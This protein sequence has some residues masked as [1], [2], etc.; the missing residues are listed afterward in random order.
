MASGISA[1]EEELIGRERHRWSENRKVYTRKIHKLNKNKNNNNTSNS[2]APTTTHANNTTTNNTDTP[3]NSKNNNHHPPNLST[4]APSVSA[5][6][7]A[8]NQTNENNSSK[9]NSGSSN[10]GNKTNDHIANGT[11]AQESEN[12]NENE[13][14]VAQQKSSSSPAAVPVEE[15]NSSQPQLIST[16]LE[17]CSED[18][19][20]L[21]R[22]EPPVPNG[23]DANLVNRLG[24]PLVT[25]V[26]NRVNISVSAASSK[27]GVRELKRQLVDELSQVRK[28]AK[29]LEDKEIH[30][31]G[32]SSSGIDVG[33]GRVHMGT[34]APAVRSFPFPAN[35][36][37]EKGVGGGGRMN[38]DVGSNGSR[39]KQLSVSMMESNHGIGEV[40]EKEKRT[41]KANQYY[42]N[43]EFLLGKDR[44]PPAES[45]KKSK[46]SGKKHRSREIDFGFGIDKQLYKKCSNLLQKLMRHKLGWVFNEPVD[47]KKLGLH[48]YFDIIKHPMDL[49]TVKTRLTKNWYKTPREFAE[50]VRLTFHNAMTYNP[51]GQD[52]H[53]MAKELLRIFEERWPA[54]ET[55]YD[56][57]LRYEVI[58]DLGVPTPTSRKSSALAHVYA[59]L[60]LLPPPLLHPPP[61]F[62]EV[63]HLGRSQ[64]MPV[65]PESRSIPA[66]VVGRTPAPKKP[67]AKDPHKR[68]MTFEEKQRLSTNLQ[69]LPAE[70]LDA[71]VQIIKKRNTALSQ[72]DDEIEVD[73]DSVDTE[74]L[75]ELDRF[76]SNY[77]KNLSKH[78]RKAELA[79]ARALAA[80][81]AQET[82]PAPVNIE[83]VKETR[84]GEVNVAT[85][86]HVQQERHSDNASGSSGSSS[87][88][89]DSGSSSSDSD[90]D[91]SSSSGS[92]GGQ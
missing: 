55:E 1:A 68:D 21:N 19:S 52:V 62:Q 66:Y 72:H 35:G 75:W 73:I 48:D 28:M 86:P 63:R 84:D 54:I 87:S 30:I 10:N 41:P 78:K 59:P 92:D 11:P 33:V 14:E 25:R 49:G 89:S 85:S 67:K 53:F 22:I 12:E 24:K 7:T 6:A 38:T 3:N 31:S 60:P 43:S 23:H 9:N 71:I 77:K 18:S 56:R 13:K 5:T 50:D 80:P 32:F 20:I 47:A 26:D 82:L 65:P 74:T 27:E 81:S 91:S 58:R 15:A 51:E 79:Q 8:D 16:R 29:R 64:S 83:A 61:P 76:V 45:N 88:S 46:S 70:R 57:K 42:R 90:S 4:A 44:L 17:T 39:F 40:M 34:A 37:V 2:T 36:V 69:S